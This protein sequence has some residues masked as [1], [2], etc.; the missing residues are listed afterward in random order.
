LP[1]LEESLVL[2]DWFMDPARDADRWDHGWLSESSMTGGAPLPAG[3]VGQPRIE[4]QTASRMVDAVLPLLAAG[5]VEW[6]VWSFGAGLF[7]YK[8]TA[9]GSALAAQRRADGTARPQDWPRLSKRGIKITEDNAAV[10]DAYLDGWEASYRAR[11][12]AKPLWPCVVSHLDPV[13]PPRRGG[14]AQTFSA[15]GAADGN[16][17]T[18]TPP[19]GGKE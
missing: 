6:R 13:D 16:A 18:T 8:L 17:K 14:T 3:T 15:A 9:E 11:R 12:E 19:N 4:E 10:W 2:L 5:L 7:L 1:R